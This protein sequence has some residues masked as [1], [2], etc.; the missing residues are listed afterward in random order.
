MTP[1]QKNMHNRLLPLFDKLLP[2]R[3]PL[4]ET[5]HDPLKNISQIDYSHHR[6]ITNFMVNLVAGLIAY[7][8][9]SR[10]SLHFA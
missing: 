3:R 5:I 4:I 8:H 6:S 10:S 2:R 7:T 9:I 1:L